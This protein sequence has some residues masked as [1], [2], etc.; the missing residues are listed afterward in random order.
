MIG[1]I[2]VFDLDAKPKIKRKRVNLIPS[3]VEIK[4]KKSS[5]TIKS[6]CDIDFQR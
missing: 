5:F 2:F 3:S 6:G 4:L 1:K